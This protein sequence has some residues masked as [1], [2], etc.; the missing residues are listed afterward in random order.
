[1]AYV[2]EDGNNGNIETPGSE[3]LLMTFLEDHD[4]SRKHAWF[5][6]SGCSNHMSGDKNLFTRLDENF[7]HSVKLGNNK[8]MEV[9]GKGNVRLI[10]NQA[11][12]VISDVYYVPELRNNLLSLRQLQEKEM[13]IL[14]QKGTCKIYHNE[15]GLLAESKISGNRMFMLFDET[16]REERPMQQQCLATVS[17]DM[18][19]LW[20]E[21][22]GH[23]SYSGMK[24]LQ[25]KGMV[26]G[27]QNFETQQL[28]CSDC[29]IGKQP[30]NSITKKSNWRAKEI[31]ELVH[32]DICGPISPT[33]AS[34]KRY[35]LCFIDDYSRKSWVYLL[36]EKSEAFNRFKLFKRKVETETGKSL[37]CLR[38]DRGREYTSHEFADYCKEHG[39][40]RQL[41]TAY[42]PQQ[43]GIAERKNRTVMN[44]V[45]SMLSARK[46]PKCFWPEAVIWTFYILN[47]CPTLAVKDV[48]PQEAWNG[49]KPTVQHF[50]VWGCVAHAHV[51]DEKR[52]KLDDKSIPCVMIGVLGRV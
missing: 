49:V 8:R 25:S 23:L 31:L 50:R 42:T 10:L 51:P 32:S 18:T 30:R 37:K 4:T 24:T 17:E 20:H 41:T 2:E 15:K 9:I 27:L 46:I 28:T 5:L 39:I 12:Y 7:K 26:R 34:G 47:R 14:I 44:M 19:R 52:G 36:N 16:R 29:L 45:R 21:R 22:Y 33:S 38:T 3:T 13:A 11:A 35:I 43:N 48:T 40:W 1:M 6:D